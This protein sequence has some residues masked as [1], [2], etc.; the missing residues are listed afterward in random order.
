MEINIKIGLLLTNKM[1]NLQN[2]K[3]KTFPKSLNPS[4]IYKLK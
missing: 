2:S 1:S 3:I 4:K